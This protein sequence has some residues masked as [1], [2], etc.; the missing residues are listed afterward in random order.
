MA[1]GRLS[2]SRGGA[3]VGERAPKER[4]RA[5]KAPSGWQHPSG[6][7]RNV[8]CAVLRSASLLSFL[9]LESAK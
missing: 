6:A 3:S 9:A 8:N 1:F 5:P 2:E 7:A 4:A